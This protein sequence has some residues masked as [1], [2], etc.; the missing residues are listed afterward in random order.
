MPSIPELPE[1]LTD[2]TVRVRMAAER[3]IPEILIAYQ[4]DPQLHVRL[5]EERPPSGAQ[6]GSLAERAEAELAAGTRL[7]LTITEPDSDDCRGQITVR[8]L[9][10]EHSRAE[11]AIWVAPQLRNR[12]FA[13]RALRLL[14]PWLFGA[15][16]LRRL[17][18]LTEP[19]NE[20]MLHAA[21]AAGFVHEGVLRS[22]TRERGARVEDAVLS[23][24]P[25]DLER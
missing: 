8:H 9:D 11:L 20:P 25:A 3:D 13:R 19:D 24:I 23:L 7:E 6:L 15:C 5:R 2:G 12:G 18:L 21:S 22:Y 14:A 1:P 16:K 10:W 4:D 17:A